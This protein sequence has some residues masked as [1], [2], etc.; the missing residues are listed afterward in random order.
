[1]AQRRPRKAVNRPPHLLILSEDSEGVAKYLRQRFPRKAA[2]QV[3]VTVKGMGCQPASLYRCAKSALR[4]GDAELVF[5]VFDRDRAPKFDETVRRVAASERI[6][7]F[8]SIPCFEYFFLLHFIPTTAPFNSFDE[9]SVPLRA[10]G[11]FANY[12][13]KQH[14]VPI[15]ALSQLEE[16]ALIN[17]RLTRNHRSQ[18]GAD[19]PYTDVDILFRLVEL[20]KRQGI[21]R[22]LDE[23][24]HDF[25]NFV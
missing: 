13:K 7:A 1:M 16:Q 12:S 20:A 23:P 2:D 6:F 3:I 15:V 17:A 4:C 10:H 24:R 9:L 5:L 18:T 14:G 19:N 21:Q 11:P 22:V 25:F 8:V